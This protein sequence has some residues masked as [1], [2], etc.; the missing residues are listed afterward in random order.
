MRHTAIPEKRRLLVT[1]LAVGLPSSSA[2]LGGT[3]ERRVVLRGTNRILGSGI[4][5]V[6]VRI[7]EGASVSFVERPNRFKG[8]SSSVSVSG[9][10]RAIGLILIPESSTDQASFFAAGRFARCSEPGCKASSDV[11]NFMFPGRFA[12]G[13][14]DRWQDLR[15][16]DYNL[17]LLADGEPAEVTLKLRGLSGKQRLY[18]SQPAPIDFKTPET[19][20]SHLAGPSYFSAGSA[21]DGGRV[22]IAIGMLSVRST[23]N[24]VP[25]AYGV[26][27][28]DGPRPPDQVAY[29]PHCFSLGLGGFVGG[30]QDDDEFDFVYLR[31]YDPGDL[32]ES[33]DGMRGH[34][35]W[36]QSPDP[37]DSVAT[38]FLTIKLK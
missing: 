36:L 26:C 17:Y 13:D 27:S 20:I 4:A 19:R 15:G 29:G 34:G 2:S 12:T 1:L 9:R 16:G 14:G 30:W 8:P 37:I 23:S 6:G 5:G 33:Q 18:P 32:P 10:G 22:G 25:S 7:P 24:P 31:L 35:V 3:P 28:Y 11:V 21:F 38:Q